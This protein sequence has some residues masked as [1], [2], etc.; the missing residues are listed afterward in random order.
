MTPL[1]L[2][3]LLAA[4]DGGALLARPVELRADRLEVQNKEQ[5]AIYSGHATAIR[6]Q[7]TL[8]CQRLEVQLDARRE[9][10]TITASGDVV[11]V[12]GDRRA[13][14]DTATWDNAT[15]VL[16][17][18]GHP[19]ARQGNREVEGER[20]TFTAGVDRFEIEQA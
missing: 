7:A 5:R 16:V 1:L 13:T 8:T 10:K 3:L 17:V 2:S 6:D 14:G 4:P 12:D 15:G 20:V 19:T 9:V 11:V 18:T